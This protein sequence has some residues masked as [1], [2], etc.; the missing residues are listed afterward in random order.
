LYTTRE[1]RL[2]Q[3]KA[4]TSDHGASIVVEAAGV[5]DAFPEGMDLLGMNGK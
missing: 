3:V 2:A 5:V 1:T 4:I